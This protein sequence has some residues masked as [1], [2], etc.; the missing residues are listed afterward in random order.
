MQRSSNLRPRKFKAT[1][2]SFRES[3]ETAILDSAHWTRS[4]RT[5]RAR[6][7]HAAAA[8]GSS[9]DPLPRLH[10]RSG[11]RKRCGTL[12]APM[13]PAL[14]TWP[15]PAA[16]ELHSLDGRVHRLGGA[17]PHGG[18][19][20]R[21]LVALLPLVGRHEHLTTSRCARRIMLQEREGGR[22]RGS[23]AR[24]LQSGTHG[25][26]SGG[27]AR[28]MLSHSRRVEQPRLDACIGRR[29]SRK[30]RAEGRRPRRAATSRWRPRRRM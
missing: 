20:A 9:N 3:R 4:S 30:R 26:G 21:R 25:E 14:E 2:C 8:T 11:S 22:L 16:C 29:S 23:T 19:Q 5:P 24:S 13:R 12:H 18:A 17:R 7:R 28:P 6:S 15:P 10:G 1:A 27:R